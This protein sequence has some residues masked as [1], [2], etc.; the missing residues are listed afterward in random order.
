MGLPNLQE[1]KIK[2]RSIRA[3]SNSNGTNLKNNKN[4]DAATIA[5][6]FQL[7]QEKRELTYS[8]IA[9]GLKSGLLSLFFVSFVRLGLASHQRIF[10]HIELTSI[11][12]SELIQ[13]VESQ[14]RFDRLFFLDGYRKLIEE[15]DQWI[16]P[17]SSRII[18][19]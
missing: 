12:D 2:K 7:R 11:L 4:I 9:L 19:R 13:L 8:V 1:N 16:E 6:S 14:R 18:W 3:R 10:R 15:Q 5:A 17:N